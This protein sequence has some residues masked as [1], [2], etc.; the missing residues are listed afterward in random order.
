[1]EQPTL[2][3]KPPELQQVAQRDRYS[4]LNVK[5]VLRPSF[6][7]YCLL[8]LVLCGVGMFAMTANV[9]T[10]QTT[11]RST[12]EHKWEGEVHDSGY[13]PPPPAS[14]DSLFSADDVKRM[15]KQLIYTIHEMAQRTTEPR[16]IVLPLFDN[17]TT[18]GVSLILELR[19]MGVHLPIEIPHCGDLKDSTTRTI[20]EQEEV[21]VLHFYDVCELASETVSLRDASVKV[22][23]E[24]LSNCYELF[25]S[26]DIKLLA[27]ILSRFEE[28]ML[29]DADTL[30]FESPM[31]L[32]DTDKYQ[33]TGTL[34]FHD[35]IGANR[36]HLGKL[37][38]RR[39]DGVRQIHDFMSRFDVSPFE[40]LGRI[41]R[42]NA[43]SKNKVPVT[44]HFSPSEH[45]LTSHSWNYRAGHEMDSSL[46]LWNKKRQPRATAILGAFVAR[47]RIDRPPS[48]GDKE[49]FF[50]ATELAET[51]YSFSDFGTG[52]AG[53]DF[54][55]YGPGKSVLC[56]TAT[57]YYP[58]K[59]KDERLVAN[60]SVLYLN[61]DDILVYDPK[62]KPL[63]YTQAR[64]CEVYPGDV[65]KSGLDITCPF[66]VT[67]VRF[68][69][70]QE[71]HM[72]LRQHF[73]EVAKAWME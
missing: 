27:V 60:A 28:V 48:Y 15:E 52:G 61:S 35:R 45:L 25:Q 19:A 37:L 10:D 2:S 30:F 41:E 44:L 38:R 21:G 65:Y 58:V 49:L 50:V 14:R 1:M 55:D 32:W 18:L 42:P 16:G 20:L 3:P 31:S 43:T 22:F 62:T 12:S 51:Q 54:R 17:I 7:R 26:F 70:E 57:H 53:W 39:N 46:V 72:L 24:S 29:L 33:S 11:G 6:L 13:R 8:V 73:Y 47:N 5:Q 66:D 69:P 23:C 63:Y 56:G 67:G 9:N 64:L 71:D 36:K 34:F 59:A 40:P 68:S 4:R